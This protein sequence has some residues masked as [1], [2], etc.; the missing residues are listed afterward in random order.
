L[1]GDCLFNFFDARIE[2]G[3][4]LDFLRRLLESSR[5]NHFPVQ[6]SALEKP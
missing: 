3:K 5:N 1:Y 2:A 6:T 4:T